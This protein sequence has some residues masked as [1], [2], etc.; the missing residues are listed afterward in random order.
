M[1]Y[2]DAIAIGVTQGL[3]VSSLAKDHLG[4]I[5]K[6][7]MKEIRSL[8]EPEV[9]RLLEDFETDYPCLY[10]VLQDWKPRITT[11]EYRDSD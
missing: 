8:P 4:N 6:Y 5:I 1:N 7:R 3:Y 10:Q 9:K 11:A 2:F